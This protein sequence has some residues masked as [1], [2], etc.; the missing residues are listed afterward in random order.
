MSEPSPKAAERARQ[1][2]LGTAEPPKIGG[3]VW[4]RS[5][6]SG[7][8]HRWVRLHGITGP[9]GSFI[10]RNELGIQKRL[11]PGEW[12]TNPADFE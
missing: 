4:T 2:A 6:K 1:E 7:D 8:E 12:R 5:R 10:A 9:D 11:K 3:V